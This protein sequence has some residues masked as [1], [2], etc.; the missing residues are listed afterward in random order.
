MNCVDHIIFLVKCL[1]SVYTL[2][3][4][5]YYSLTPPPP[6]R[7]TN[8]LV[9]VVGISGA[10]GS[11]CI[12]MYDAVRDVL[13]YTHPHDIRWYD[14]RE[15]KLVKEGVLILWMVLYHALFLKSLSGE[16]VSSRLQERLAKDGKLQHFKALGSG[17]GIHPSALSSI[18]VH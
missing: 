15:R 8:P 7:L 9:P 1:G 16:E 3:R 18:L 5:C 17:V 11:L 12:T 10:R 13:M 4:V 6:P 2:N 14:G